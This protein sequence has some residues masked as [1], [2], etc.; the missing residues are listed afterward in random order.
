M[1]GGPYND[2]PRRAWLVVSY[3]NDFAGISEDRQGYEGPGTI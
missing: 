2:R 1:N 3:N